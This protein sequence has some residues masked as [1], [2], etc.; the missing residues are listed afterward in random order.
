MPLEVSNKWKL[1]EA[2]ELIRSLQPKVKTFGFHLCLGGGVLNKG[3]S[4]KDLDLYFLSLGKS[5]EKVKGKELVEWLEKLWGESQEF[6]RLAKVS[7]V[8][9]HIQ[10]DRIRGYNAEGQPV[11]YE[12]DVFHGYQP[13]N[14]P[15][16]DLY[17]EDEG[18]IT[19][20]FKGKFD[21]SGL[22]IDVFVLGEEKVEIDRSIKSKVVE[23][24]EGGAINIE[25][26]QDIRVGPFR[27]APAPRVAQVRV[28]AQ[29]QADLLAELRRAMYGENGIGVVA[30]PAVAQNNY[31]VMNNNAAGNWVEYIGGAGNAVA[32]PAA[33][34]GWQWENMPQNEVV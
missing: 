23:G 17:P 15:L 16:A 9:Q 22:R 12:Y 8:P 33:Q 24:V 13:I 21:Y 30:A 4:E 29:P 27:E 10:G 14:E 3:F 26:D 2:L 7:E 34:V 28:A 1:D 32:Q 11:M 6:S 18:S 31:V 5:K 25:V 20:V 19:Y